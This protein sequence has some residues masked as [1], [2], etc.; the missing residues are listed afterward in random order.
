MVIFLVENWIF[1]VFSPFLSPLRLKHVAAVSDPL[2][3]LL[4]LSI[5]S[6]AHLAIF[7]KHYFEQIIQFYA[8]GGKNSFFSRFLLSFLRFWA[9]FC[10]PP[11]FHPQPSAAKQTH[12]STRVFACSVYRHSDFGSSLKVIR[13]ARYCSGTSSTGMLRGTE[14]VPACFAVS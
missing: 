4:S 6:I 10:T 11:P 3:L 5:V 14:V 12:R 13:A 1:I 9:K 7:C 2:K 8:C